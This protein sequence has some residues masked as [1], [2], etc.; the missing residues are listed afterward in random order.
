MDQTTIIPSQRPRQ[1]QATQQ[2]ESDAFCSHAE[3]LLRGVGVSIADRGFSISD[4]KY[5][6]DDPFFNSQSAFRN[7]QWKQPRPSPSPSHS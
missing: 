4:L 6:P 7:P 3:R 1:S 2:K 5:E